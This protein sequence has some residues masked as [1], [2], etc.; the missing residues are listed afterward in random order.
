MRILYRIRQAWRAAVVKP[1]PSDEFLVNKM[2][3]PSMVAK[4][5]QLKPYD[6][7]H[8]I[9]IYHRLVQAGEIQND[10]LVA[11]LLHDIGKICYPLSLW[12][13]V[14]IVV[15]NSLFPGASQ[16]WGKGDPSSWR[17]PFV[18][19]ENH[20]AW[21]SKIAL[22]AG[23]SPLAATIIDR[24]QDPVAFSKNGKANLAGDQDQISDVDF[25]VYKLQLFDH[26]N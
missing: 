15:F 22:E 23:A 17:R 14:V 4:F 3:T 18:V 12:E 1:R 13:R 5:N 24:H 20:P 25:L 19:A 10:L 26:R 16:N 2:L 21:G 8:S 11:A 9:H 7:A 6:Q